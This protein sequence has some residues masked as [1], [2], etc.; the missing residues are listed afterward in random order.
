MQNE[1]FRVRSEV[2]LFCFSVPKFQN[3][4]KFGNLAGFWLLGTDQM[5]CVE[6]FMT[7]NVFQ[8]FLFAFLESYLRKR[9][10]DVL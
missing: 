2:M 3:K 5:F 1:N 6:L 4:I 10:K 8:T 9:S 7:K